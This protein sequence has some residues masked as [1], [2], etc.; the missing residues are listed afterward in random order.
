MSDFV[1]GFWNIYV[2]G[3]TILSI[4]GCAWLLYANT[5][6]RPSGPV[7]LHGHIWDENLQEYNHPLPRWW[8]WLF[9]LTIA[10][11]LLYLAVYPGLGSFKGGFGWTSTG[12]YDAEMQ[13]ANQLYAPKFNQFLSQDVQTVAAN[14]E[15]KAMGERLFLTYCMQCHGS[16]ARG[17]KGFPNL[18]D[19][20]WL[21]GGHADQIKT[22]ITEGR[23]GVMPPFGPALGNEGVKDVANYV[24]SLSGLAADG[25]RVERGKAVFEQNCVACHGA[26]A[27][28]M[29]AVG[30]PNLTDK[31][32]LYSS[33]E[34]TIIETV[35]KGRNNRMP[36]FKEFLGDAKV[37]LLSAYVF[38]LGGGQAGSSAPAPAPEPATQAGMEG[39]SGM[40]GM[41]GM[42][43]DSAASAPMAKIYFDSGKSA[44]PSDTSDS[45]KAIIDYATGNAGAKLAISGFH[46]PSGSQAVNEELAKQRAKAVREAL[47]SAGIAEDRI[48]MRKPQVTTGTGDAKEAR[49]VE[50]S[51]I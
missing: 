42:A 29:Q 48:E 17:A 47:M 30:A 20:D 28:G 16:D 14:P 19:A 23:N 24:R 18:T 40:T 5:I 41:A 10:F 35:T 51:V 9:Y 31:T 44:L 4:L 2:A 11:A 26:D 21:Y 39:M 15:A 22:T 38:G 6:R 36:A 45:L 50:V 8:M 7:Q 49:R 25:Q 34:A 13:K 27:K 37:H 46:D 3:L 43:G 33:N 12:Q 32:W 1:S